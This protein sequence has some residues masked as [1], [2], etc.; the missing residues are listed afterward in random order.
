MAKSRRSAAATYADDRA[1]KADQTAKAEVDQLT[2]ARA[3]ATQAAKAEADARQEVAAAITKANQ[4]THHR[5]VVEGKVFHLVGR[6]AEADTEAIRART[7]AE[8]THALE[9]ATVPMPLSA[10]ETGTVIAALD[11]NPG[12][13]RTMTV[14]LSRVNFEGTGIVVGAALARHIAEMVGGDWTVNRA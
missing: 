5:S 10:A 8:L 14:N 1:A 9:A 3:E 11:E 2:A 7:L 4:A 12:V 6:T 13:P